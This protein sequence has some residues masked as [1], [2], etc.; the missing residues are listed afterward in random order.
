VRRCLERF[1]SAFRRAKS[2]VERRGVARPLNEQPEHLD[3]GS[4][5]SEREKPSKTL[6]PQKKSKGNKTKRSRARRRASKKLG[7]KGRRKSKRRRR[8]TKRRAT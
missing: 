7:K 4:R 2:L 5:I 6:K 1:V 8:K 3:R